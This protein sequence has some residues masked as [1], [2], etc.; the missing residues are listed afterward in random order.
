[1]SPLCIVKSPCGDSGFESAQADFI[2]ISEEFYSPA[3][4]FPR[5]YREIRTWH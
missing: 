5:L 4:P 2:M 3:R 1:M